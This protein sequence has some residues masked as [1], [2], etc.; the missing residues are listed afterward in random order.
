ME[1]G[2]ALSDGGCSH[3]FLPLVPPLISISNL[4]S[5]SAL[6]EAILANA[7]KSEEADEVTYC[8]CLLWFLAHPST[9]QSNHHH[10]HH[11]HDRMKY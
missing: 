1:G 4:S 3:P 6:Y 11:H 8:I 10:H 9:K 5:D 7:I 2:L